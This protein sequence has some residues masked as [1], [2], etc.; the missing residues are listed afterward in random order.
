MGAE[1]ARIAEPGALT[2][3]DSLWDRTKKV[4]A[5]IAPLA[6]SGIVGAAAHSPNQLCMRVL[7]FVQS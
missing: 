2:M 6:G 4:S 1:S 3:P 5:V 7:T